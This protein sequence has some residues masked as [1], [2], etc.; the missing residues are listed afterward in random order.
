M[1][2]DATLVP[3]APGVMLV[4][5]DRL[6]VV[7]RQLRKWRIIRAPRPVKRRRRLLMSSPWI[8]INVLML[9]EKHVIVDRAETPLIDCLGRNG[10]QVVTAS[11]DAFNAFGG[12]FHCATLDVRREDELR[13]Y[14]P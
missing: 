12:S 4:N 11:L 9:D 10:F 1:H 14:S 2:L 8:S 13:S 5:A 6:P 3:L 7:P